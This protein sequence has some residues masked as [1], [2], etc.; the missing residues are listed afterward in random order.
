MANAEEVVLAEGVWK[1]KSDNVTA[2]SALTMR[3]ALSQ[4]L[5]AGYTFTEATHC[6]SINAAQLMKLSTGSIQTGANA[7]LLVLTKDLR[8]QQVWLRGTPIL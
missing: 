3:E 8:L 4:L 5:Q 2:G 1:R 6:T 7:D